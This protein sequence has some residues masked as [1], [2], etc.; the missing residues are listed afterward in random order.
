[1]KFTRTKI[2]CTIGPASNK[3]TILK[4]LHKAGMNVAR[5][6]MSHATHDNAKE[7]IDSIKQINSSVAGSISK[8]G[9]LLDTQGPEIR[10]G[11]TSLPI[12]LK[13]GDKVTLTVRDEID[14]ETSSI[15]VN[16]K[17][18]IESVSVGSQITVDNGLINFKVLSKQSET[19]LCKV[20]HGGKIGSKRHVNLPGVRINMPSITPKD[21][22]D[23]EFG[24][25]NNVDFI[26]ASF[27]RSEKDLNILEQILSK[28]KSKAKIIAKIENQEGLENIENISKSAWGIMVARGDLGIETSLTD[29]PNIQR[30]IMYSCAVHGKRSI[31]ATHLLESMINNPTPTRA[32]VTDIANAIYEGADALMLSGETSVGKYP[33]ECV[34]FLKSLSLKTEQ[35]KTLGY[36]SN[37]V[38]NSDWESIAMTAKNLSESIKADGIIAITRTGDTAN[39]ISNAKPNGIP[40][41]TF[42]NNLITLNQLS[43]VGSTHSFFISRLNDHDKTLSHVKKEL[44]KYFK[45]KKNLK[46]VMLSGIFSE[47]HSEAIQIINF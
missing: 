30:K 22:Q 46:F 7:I 40:I 27:V 24:I 2:I 17:G 11:D 23:I 12:E 6:N 4:K 18:L 34:Q 21:I 16:Y 20:I 32:E 3:T 10:T 44:K 45:K 26:A 35:F 14:V 19:L 29:L 15:K 42:T 36:E 1:M 25:K 9:I 13:V 28:K 37:L 5:I 33:I 8:I 43:L 31:V 38:T 47:D 41:F 39:Y